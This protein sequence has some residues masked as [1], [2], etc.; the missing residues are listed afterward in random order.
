[1]SDSP[2]SYLQK[3]DNQ[4]NVCKSQKEITYINRVI[5]KMYVNTEKKSP[6]EK[7]KTRKCM[8]DNPE[9]YVHK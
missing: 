1:M 8:S 6:T 5:K 3:Q 2:E 7:R 4:E 9:S